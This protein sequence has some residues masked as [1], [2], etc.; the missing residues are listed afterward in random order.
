MPTRARKEA[1]CLLGLVRDGRDPAAAR[2]KAEA[3]PTL[4]EFCDRY[5]TEYAAHH[6]RFVGRLDHQDRL[7]RLI[8]PMLG[9]LKLIEVN[10]VMSPSSMPG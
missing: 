4:A 8:L 1:I 9:K 10:R 3:V 2:D 5:M 6:Q 7:D